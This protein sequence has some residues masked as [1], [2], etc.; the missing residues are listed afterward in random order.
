MNSITNGD[1]FKR[2]WEEGRQ[3]ALEGKNR[4][5]SRMGLSWK[6]VFHGSTALDSYTDGYNN[7]YEVGINEKNVVRKVEFTNNYNNMDYNTANTQQLV[8]ELQALKDLNDFVVSC[9]NEV[10]QV[11]GYFR[12]YILMM[13]DTGITFEACK[14]FA[15]KY[16]VEDEANFKSLYDRI[17]NYDIPWIRKYMEQIQRQFQAA[18]GT[19]IGSVNLKMPDNTISS[20]T[21]NGVQDRKGGPMD[22]EIQYDALCDFMNFMVEKRD[23]LQHVIYEYEKACNNMINSG[24]PKQIVEHY[25]PNFAQPNV[26]LINRTIAHIQQVDYPQ[27][28]KLLVEIANSL[29]EL[30]RSAN[31]APKNM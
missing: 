3:A 20:V 8:R 30:G 17:I 13:A 11:N 22:Y 19:N 6:F 21:P 18:D 26:Q 15:D 2:G 1:D 25:I 7:G 31:R 4:D 28:K 29:G 23:E 5:Y 12:S 24:V 27:L 16:Y 14:E 9:C 10:R